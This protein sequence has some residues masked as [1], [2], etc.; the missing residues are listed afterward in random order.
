[1]ATEVVLLK[2]DYGKTFSKDSTTGIKVFIS[3]AALPN[4]T[5]V[6]LPE[7][8]DSYDD[9]YI[10]L[11]VATIDESYIDDG[12]NHILYTV[13]YSTAAASEP[14]EDA[15]YPIT[16]ETDADFQTYSDSKEEGDAVGHWIWPDGG[17]VKNTEFRQRIKESTQNFVV[18]REIWDLND[19][20]WEDKHVTGRI[21][22]VDTTINGIDV[23][24]ETCLYL[25]AS[26]SETRTANGATKWLAQLK[27]SVKEVPTPDPAV[28][29]GW[30]HVFRPA[31]KSYYK[32][33]FYFK[34]DREPPLSLSEVYVYLFADFER[35]LTIGG[36]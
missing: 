20:L 9:D 24:A 32:P 25:G 1:M 4:S 22:A 30:N 12:C 26:I 35:I 10:G 2:R 19:F 17:N 21:N 36:Q 3:A 11:R 18:H 5:S 23:K 27:F 15:Y 16:L 6:D 34:K 14:D 13:N 33:Y 31:K 29:G 28:N 7:L 8:G